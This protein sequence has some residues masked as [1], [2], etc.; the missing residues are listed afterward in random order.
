MKKRFK[1]KVFNK[2]RFKFKVFNTKQTEKNTEK[3]VD[4]QAE[5]L[6]KK[7]LD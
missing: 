6:N 1:F 3:E 4:K 5:A 2:E 7:R